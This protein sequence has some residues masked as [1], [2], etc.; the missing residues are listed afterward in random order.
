MTYANAIVRLK[1]ALIPALKAGKS[2]A[3]LLAEVFR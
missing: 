2:I 1:R 3:G